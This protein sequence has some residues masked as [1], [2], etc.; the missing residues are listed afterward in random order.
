LLY[1][2]S[3]TLHFD[4]AR[5]LWIFY[6]QN[7]EI[8]RFLRSNG[9]IERSTYLRIFLIGCIDILITFPL[10]VTF[11]VP[12]IAVLRSS[13]QSFYAGW[14]NDHTDWEPESVSYA[15]LVENGSW[16][17]ANYYT[18]RWTSI[19]LGLAISV[20][21]GLT[22]DARASYL[23]ILRRVARILGFKIKQ[24]KHNDQ[25]VSN[26]VF[27]ERNPTKASNVEEQR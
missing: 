4:E 1:L 14:R 12:V 21:F 6:R 20:L 8:N 27:G 18:P 5:I 22:E 13:H 10:G 11:I 3:I 2:R 23:R 7:T 16:T 19:V 26:I 24:T 15:S 25:R 9:S 17:I